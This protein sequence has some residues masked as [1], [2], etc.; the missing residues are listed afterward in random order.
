MI[1]KVS[2]IFLTTRAHMCLAEISF[3]SSTHLNTLLLDAD[4]VHLNGMKKLKSCAS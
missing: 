2:E 4:R 1:V 3:L